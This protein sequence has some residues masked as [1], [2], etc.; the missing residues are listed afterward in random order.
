MVLDLKTRDRLPEDSSTSQTS[1]QPSVVK[2]R[3]PT[4]GD[5]SKCGRLGHPFMRRQ[6]SRRLLGIPER[7]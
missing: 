7:R 4:I 2:E 1:T 6:P 5:V 3:T